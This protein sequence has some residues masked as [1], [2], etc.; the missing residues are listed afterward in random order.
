MQNVTSVNFSPIVPRSASDEATHD[1]LHMLV[2]RG[3]PYSVKELQNASG[4]KD[5]CIEAAMA[6]VGGEHFRRLAPENFWSIAQ[7]LGAPF[8]NHI[9]TVLAN[10]GAFNLP[11]DE[12]PQPGEFAAESAE[13]HA[14]IAVAAADGKFGANDHGKLWLVGQEC[15]Q[16]GMQLVGLGST[17]ARQGK[18]A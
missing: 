5:R 15:I 14:Q 3:K 18:A 11:N 1:A 7:A 9:T 8:L 10:V 12:L 17:A 16:R 4:V 2:G 6:P 13:D